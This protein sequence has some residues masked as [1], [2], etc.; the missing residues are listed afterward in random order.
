MNVKSILKKAKNYYDEYEEDIQIYFWLTVFGCVC[1][2]FGYQV[3]K[4]KFDTIK[5]GLT[6]ACLA[7][8][9]LIDHMKEATEKSI[10]IVKQF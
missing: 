3:A 6:Y 4:A 5:L 9:T 7:D 10:N 2:A 8:P 1:S